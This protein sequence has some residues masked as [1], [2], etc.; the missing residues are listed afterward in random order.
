MPKLSLRLHLPM[1]EVAVAVGVE[2]K[3]GAE[4]EAAH[5]LLLKWWQ[6]AHSLWALQQ[7]VPALLAVL[8]QLLRS[9]YHQKAVLHH[10]VLAYLNPQRR[11]SSQRNGKQK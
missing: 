7:L 3:E 4:V 11:K 8:L 5:D 1:I 9:Q 10:L 6:V 2:E